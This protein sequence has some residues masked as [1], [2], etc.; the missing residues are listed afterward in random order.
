[1]AIGIGALILVVLTDIVVGIEARDLNWAAQAAYLRTSAGQLY[2][3]L[4]VAFAAMPAVL[5][6]VSNDQ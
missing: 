1:M 5:N 6:A 4:L 3:V 2:L